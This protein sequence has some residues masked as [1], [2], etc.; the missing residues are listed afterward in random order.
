MISTFICHHCGRRCRCNP[1]LKNQKYCSAEAC[2]QARKNTWGKTEYQTN[3]THR[4]KRLLSQKRCYKKREGDAYQNE[5]RKRHPDYVECNREQQIIRNR[6][7]NKDESS[8]IVN[9]DALSL[10]PG[11]DGVYALMQVTTE[12]KIVNTDAFMVQLQALPDLQMF[13]TPNTG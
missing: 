6:K 1:R 5:Y 8:K 10:Y 9:T 3:E 13:S 7:R 12:G 4:Q 11:I 2:Q